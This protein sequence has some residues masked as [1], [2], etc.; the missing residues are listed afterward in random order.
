MGVYE[1]GFECPPGEGAGCSSISEVNEMVNKGVVP[2]QKPMK[3]RTEGECGECPSSGEG[4]TPFG[5]QAEP[6]IWY[7][8]EFVG[9]VF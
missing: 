9:G 1:G 6:Q 2:K 5:H 7:S 8:P 3:D 4:D